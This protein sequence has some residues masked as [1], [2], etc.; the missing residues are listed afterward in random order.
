MSDRASKDKKKS[1]AD[2][3]TSVHLSTG[4]E[5]GLYYGFVPIATPSITPADTQVA[6]KISEG[7]IIIDSDNH[8]GGAWAKLEE[9]IALLRIYDE[10]NL[11][12]EPQP[13]MIST[14]RPFKNDRTKTNAKESHHSFDILGTNRSIAEAILI[15][16]ALALLSKDG[17]TDVHL[18][19]NSIGDKDSAVRFGRELSAFYK[20]HLSELP[21]A[22]REKFKADPFSILGCTHEKCAELSLECP[23][24]INFLSEESRTR[25]KEILEFVEML[26][27]PYE[28]K[29]NLVANRDYCSE[30]VF[31]IRT[32]DPKD[33]PLAV[34]VRYDTLAKKVGYKKE[35]PAAG[36]SVSYP[37]RAKR[38]LT[39]TKANK[40]SR[41]TICF[42]QLGYEA[43]LKALAV[44]E[45]LRVA[46][47]P[48]SHAL[49]R[50][51]MAGQVSLSEYMKTTYVIIMGK[52]EAME[53]SVIIRHTGTRAQETVFITDLAKHIKRHRIA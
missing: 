45:I 2:V 27:I 19:I 47:I 44:I 37:T 12:R 53:D 1:F 38:A 30:T 42:M 16:T 17:I 3:V 52:K 24:A 9:K 26:G 39:K 48:V 11:S 25:F 7:E 51:K 13:V 20:R 36:V 31:E 49:A 18:E 5:V 28:I 15:K 22:C 23:K 43:K 46:N 32:S 41:P 8:E 40:I 21:A 50:D 4:H 34:G 29:N 35:V 33:H 10:Y 6:K 14:T